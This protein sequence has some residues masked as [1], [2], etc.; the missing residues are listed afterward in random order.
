[1]EQNGYDAFCVGGCIRDSL[2]GLSPKDWD[3]ASSALPEECMR[4]FG[5]FS[6]IPTGI[7][8]GTVTVIADTHPLEI[9]TFRIDGAY[10]ENRRPKEVSFTKDIEED[11]SRRDFTINAI[12]YNKKTGFI[13]PFGGISDLQNRL[14]R[15]VGNAEKRFSED[16]LRIL[17]CVRFSSQLGFTID[18]STRKAAEDL[19]HLLSS[20]SKERIASELSKILCGD[21]AETALREN[22]DI[23]FVILPELKPMFLCAQENP[24]HI[25]GV[26]EHSLNALGASPKNLPIRLA[27]LFHDSGKPSVKTYGNDG[28]AHFYGHA[29]ASTG[30][31]DAALKRLKYPLHIQKLVH[32][33]IQY[34]DY[35]LPMKNIKIKR[36]LQEMGGDDFFSLMEVYK[37]DISAQSPNLAPSRLPIL[38]QTCNYAENLI[39]NDECLSLKQL[40]I[41][42]DDLI[43][44]GCPCGN[45]IGEILNE[46]LELVLLEQIPNKRERL[47]T[48]AERRISQISRH[49]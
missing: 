29:K 32:L 34:H 22:S 10:L 1:M 12:A 31:A 16:S 47:L 11:L 46:L 19:S 35:P 30:I 2:L 39:K 33:L 21:F 9:T 28:I 18:I 41:N 13:D 43:Y 14:I 20:I 42:G 37:A 24:Y 6:V 25:Y 23:I 26:W 15:T 8:H 3:I 49:S 44:L 40:A 45:N 38:K 36:L 27:L 17:R 7:K 4:I 48:V 5:D